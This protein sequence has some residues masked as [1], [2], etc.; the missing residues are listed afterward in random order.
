MSLIYFILAIF[1]LLTAFLIVR[2]RIYYLNTHTEIYNASYDGHNLFLDKLF[3]FIRFIVKKIQDSSKHFYQDILHT[4][5]KIVSKLNSL[6]EKAYTK[7][8]DKF[9]NEVIKDKKSVPHFW[10]HLKKY[11]KEIDQESKENK[12]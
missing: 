11:K 3:I 1:C 12:V 9:V 7:S 2:F 8:R 6:S 10:D 5:V 4:W